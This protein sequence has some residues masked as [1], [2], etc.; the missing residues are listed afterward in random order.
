[1]DDIQPGARAVSASFLFDNEACVFRLQG[2]H[3]YTIRCGINKWHDSSITADGIP[4]EITEYFWAPQRDGLNTKVASAGAGT[5]ADTFEL[6]LVDDETP[7][8][9]K[10][11]CQFSEN[12]VRIRFT[13]SITRIIASYREKRP[14]LIERMN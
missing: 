4:P 12:I 5:G 3:S 2:K 8:Y 11:G 14:V 13:N 6:C 9:D 10:I 7:H 1:M